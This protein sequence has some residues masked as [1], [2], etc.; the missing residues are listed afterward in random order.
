MAIEIEDDSPMK[1]RGISLT[2]DIDKMLLALA[3]YY[4]TNAS[5]VIRALIEQEYLAVQEK[6]DS[7]TQEEE[8]QS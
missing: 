4:D 6:T 5:A 8:P 1:T 7:E 2:E 3:E